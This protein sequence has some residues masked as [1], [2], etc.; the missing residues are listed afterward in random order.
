MNYAIINRIVG[1]G[2]ELVALD[3]QRNDIDAKT[4]T[5]LGEV[6]RLT[7]PKGLVTED[8]EPVASLPK[9]VGTGRL[10]VAGGVE[11]AAIHRSG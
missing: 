9:I 7:R 3:K 5:L 10:T 11:H 1:I 2:A 8:G 6:H 4:K